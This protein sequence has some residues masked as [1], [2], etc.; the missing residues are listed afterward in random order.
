MTATANFAF[1]AADEVRLTEWMVASIEIRA[2]ATPSASLATLERAVGGQ[3]RPPLDQEREPFW[4]PNPWREAVASAREH[5][6][7]AL[8]SEAGIEHR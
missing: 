7:H 2:Y 1:V 8:R 3:L 6:R 5:I 4:S